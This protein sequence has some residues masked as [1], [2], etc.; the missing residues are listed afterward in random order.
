[1]GQLSPKGFEVWWKSS[2]WFWSV[3]V[4]SFH[5][6]SQYGEQYSERLRFRESP[7][8][9]NSSPITA[10]REET[11]CGS[12]PAA[13]HSLSVLIH[14]FSVSHSGNLCHL[15]GPHCY[16]VNTRPADEGE[17]DDSSLL[18][19]RSSLTQR[20]CWTCRLWF[21]VVLWKTVEFHIGHNLVVQL[22]LGHKNSIETE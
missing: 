19:D 10:V 11:S 3:G 18:R 2:W 13:L 17:L 14:G 21:C 16:T 20:E 6:W 7:S 15:L 4:D 9:L 1:M 8:L 22:C 12:D 5:W